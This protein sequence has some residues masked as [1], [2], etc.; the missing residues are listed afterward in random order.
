MNKFE[1]IYSIEKDIQI[2]KNME[3][4]GWIYKEPETQKELSNE[5]SES[6]VI[7]EKP[8]KDYR[9]SNKTAVESVQN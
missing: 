2:S 1:K 8:K 9:K 6:E 4:E 3:F 7:K 5:K